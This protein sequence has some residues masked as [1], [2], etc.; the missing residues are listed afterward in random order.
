MITLHDTLTREKRAFVP[1]NPL[2]V[3]TPSIEA[4][5]W[6]VAPFLFFATRAKSEKYNWNA[7]ALPRRKRLCGC[8]TSS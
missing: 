7:C 8:E 2:I 1:Q 6:F 4:K 3:D 5:V